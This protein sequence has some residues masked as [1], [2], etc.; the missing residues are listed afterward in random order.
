MNPLD[1][2]IGWENA[3]DIGG[4][5]SSSLLMLFL[6]WNR[7]R[8]RQ[9]VLNKN[10]ASLT[11]NRFGS[12]LSVEILRHRA[13][14]AYD[15]VSAILDQELELLVDGMDSSAGPSATFQWAQ[16]AAPAEQP[17]ESG[18]FGS[19]PAARDAAYRTA[20]QLAVEGASV[21]SI[22][23]ACGITEEEAEVFYHLQ[24]FKTDT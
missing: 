4:L 1:I 22:C 13:R 18:A 17:G 20:T 12:Q 16:D 21:D 11:D 15:S 3:L 9:W 7:C 2:S 10:V 19:E 6:I 23:S 14:K 24:R 5:I 8:Y